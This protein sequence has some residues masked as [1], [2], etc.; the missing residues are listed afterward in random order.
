M[1]EDAD[2]KEQNSDDVDEDVDEIAFA[3]DENAESAEPSAA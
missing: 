1:Q 3:D 2:T